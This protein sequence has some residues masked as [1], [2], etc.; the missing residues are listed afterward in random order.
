MWTKNIVLKSGLN[1]VKA[2]DYS[3]RY[4]KTTGKKLWMITDENNIPIQIV[5]KV[6]SS[7]YLD[8]V[9]TE[10]KYNIYFSGESMLS[11]TWK[12]LKWAVWWRWLVWYWSFDEIIDNSFIDYSE[13]A[14]T[15]IISWWVSLWTW[16]SWKSA[17][18]DWVDWEFY[19]DL[20]KNIWW[21]S[22]S[23][24]TISAWIKPN[25]ISSWTDNSLREWVLVLWNIDLNNLWETWPWT[26][27]W[28]IWWVDWPTQFWIW[29]WPQEAPGITASVWQ[30]IIVTFDWNKIKSYVNWNINKIK[31]RE[32]N[33][34]EMNIKDSH[35]YIWKNIS[36]SF[37]WWEIDELRIYNRALSEKEIK[38]I[39]EMDK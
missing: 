5:E 18:F 4:I 26:H 10:D 17:V 2:T 32:V 30:N 15:W 20:I 27:H 16:Q 24:H 39:Y 36:N 12:T 35:L 29:D 38:L 23:P 1:E 3:E 21:N 28:L 9:N 37:Y 8:I 25:S 14:A 13:N 6:T 7:W 22:S 33:N 34:T 31:S 19:V 11:W